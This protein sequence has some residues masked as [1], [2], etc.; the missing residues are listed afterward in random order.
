LLVLA[1]CGG[2][3][4]RPDAAS[5]VTIS[6]PLVTTGVD[7]LFV[8]DNSGSM[9]E[10]QE[11]LARTFSGFVSA[12]EQLESGLPNL[13]I[14]VVSSDM[15]SL[16]VPTGDPACS[17]PD[18]GLLLK[19]DPD[20]GAQCLQ[21]QGRYVADV[22]NGDGTRAVNYTGTLSDA[23]SCIAWI[24]RGGCGFEQHLES[25]RAALSTPDNGDFYRPDAALAIIVIA[26][27]D[28]CSATDVRFFAPEDEELGP[29]DSFRCF[30]K[31]VT[32]AE[33]FGEALRVPG[34]KTDCR[35]DDS[36]DLLHDVGEY[37]AF[38]NDLKPDPNDILVATLVGDREPVEVTLRTPTGS[39]E[40]RA[41]LA[42]SCMHTDP[43]G[44]TNTA[45]PAI[46]LDTLVQ[47]F[48]GRTRGDRICQDDYAATMEAIAQDIGAMLRE[49]HCLQPAIALPPDCDLSYRRITEEGPLPACDAGATTRPCFRLVE[50]LAACAETPTHL[51]LVVEGLAPD[52]LYPTEITGSCR[53]P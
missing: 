21:V 44:N 27:E 49:T 53:A 37:V 28:D 50:N 2:S 20:L 34:V 9:S 18:R 22:N 43:A 7:I 46:R 10:E 4:G 38:L 40:S 15:G 12:L 1:A 48:A 19:G 24:G 45:D 30:E 35:V 8:I 25:M 3:G 11:Q 41:D 36:Q 29:L 52:P 14:G 51:E 13:H 26:D 16:G 5:R 6:M 32:C 31:A 33:G 17:D 47:R 39:T 42:P 23:L